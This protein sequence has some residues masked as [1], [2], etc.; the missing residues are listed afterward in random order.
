MNHSTSMKGMHQP[1]YKHDCPGC[2]FLGHFMHE[3]DGVHDLYLCNNSVVA[4]RSNNPDLTFGIPVFFFVMPGMQQ[5]QAAFPSLAYAHRLATE[6][7][8]I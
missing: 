6:K 8:L 3:I 1:Y 2:A 4:V 7:G 5:Y